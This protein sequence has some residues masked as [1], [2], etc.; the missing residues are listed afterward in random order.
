[1]TNITKN[2]QFRVIGTENKS[3][4]VYI[5]EVAEYINAGGGG[6]QSSVTVNDITDATTVGKNVL[7]ASTQVQARTAIGAGT[8][9]LTIGTTAT[10]AKAGNYAPPNASTTVDGLMLSTDK[11]KLDVVATGATKNQSDVILLNR[12]NHTGTQPISSITGVVPI[13]QI[14][15]GSTATTVALGNHTHAVATVTVDGLMLSADKA[16]LDVVA[17]GATKNQS[18]VILLNRANHT[19][20]Q[21]ISSITGVVPIAQ[22]PTGSTATTVALGNHTHAVATTAVAGLMSGVDKTKL[23]NLKGVILATRPTIT[24]TNPPNAGNIQASFNT[25]LNYI[26]AIIGR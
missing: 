20:T 6:G 5:D 22:I 18:D 15:T 17:T 25:I 10:T 7:L 26:D 12:A 21:P 19:G 8:S 3:P 16:K 9:D 1:M 13:A 11:V 14:P 23:D 24:I 2:T 4:L